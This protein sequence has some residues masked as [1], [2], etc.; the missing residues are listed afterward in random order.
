M[1]DLRGRALS[2]AQLDEF[3]AFYEAAPSERTRI[4]EAAREDAAKGLW[5]ASLEQSFGPP[6]VMVE[7]L[8]C[9][10]RLWCH[11]GT[12]MQEAWREAIAG[13]WL[14]SEVRAPPMAT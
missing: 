1:T 6:T 12:L 5:R 14:L 8:E 13:R 11:S 10:R 3:V 4:V 2:G 9:R 7:G